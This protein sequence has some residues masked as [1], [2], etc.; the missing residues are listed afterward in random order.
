MTH[1]FYIHNIIAMGYLSIISISLLHMCTMRS[2][3]YSYQFPVQLFKDLMTC[4][5]TIYFVNDYV[6]IMR[7][8]L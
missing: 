2:K 7:Y 1:V 4:M 3:Y 5:L 6:C 8:L